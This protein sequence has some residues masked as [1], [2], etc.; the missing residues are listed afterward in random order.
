MIIM[1]NILCR[2][3]HRAKWNPVSVAHASS[4]GGLS[5]A[6]LRAHTTQCTIVV[7]KTTI[8]IYLLYYY[9]VCE[10][11]SYYYNGYSSRQRLFPRKT[12]TMRTHTHA[13]IIGNNNSIISF[14]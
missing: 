12:G 4:W 10:G 11:R 5:C 1:I 2:H 6:T 14:D 8:Y 7:S 3:R 9:N 13:V